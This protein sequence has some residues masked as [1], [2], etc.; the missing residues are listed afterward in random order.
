[1]KLQTKI[2]ESPVWRTESDEAVIISVNVWVN[3][4][5]FLLVKDWTTI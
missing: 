5:S 1:M 2:W 3:E 4:S